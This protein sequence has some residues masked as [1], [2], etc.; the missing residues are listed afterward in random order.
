[1]S[2]RGKQFNPSHRHLTVVP[3]PAP[4]LYPIPRVG[5]V[6]GLLTVVSEPETTPQ[7]YTVV[8]CV[9]AC[10]QQTRLTKRVERFAPGAELDCGCSAPVPFGTSTTPRSEIIPYGNG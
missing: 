8:G 10:W 7:G 5:E 1:M 6:F 3:P 9:C 2:G 4:H